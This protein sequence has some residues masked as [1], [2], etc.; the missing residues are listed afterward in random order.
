MVVGTNV[1]SWYRA[2][3]DIEDWRPD[4][5]VFPVWT[6]FL[7]PAIGTI[8]RALRRR[9]CETC[10]I[11][12]NAFDHEERGWKRRFSLYALGAGDRYVTH[13]ATLASQIKSHFKDAEVVVFPH[14]IFDDFPQAKQSLK[15]RAAIELLFFGLVR[16]Y[17][18]LDIAIEALARSERTDIQL[19]VAGEFW[20]GLSETQAQIDRL[21][22]AQQIEVIPRYISDAE[23]AE[24]F[25]RADAVL[26]PYRSVT[27]S[28]VVSMSFFY[29]RPVIVS[30]LPGISELVHEFNAGWVF[31]TG[32]VEAL[33][34]V[35]ANLDREATAQV[36]LHVN[37]CR[38]VLTWENF[39]RKIL[40][41][42][43]QDVDK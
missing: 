14:P 21:G 16:P 38:N 19:T 42:S 41:S 4:L 30:D 7:A 6:F 2:I 29:N 18:G 28:G 15:P 34:N 36:S 23:T 9:G 13:G 27:G 25:D 5:V 26:L 17:K 12:H 35:L 22:I 20:Q 37:R 24:L 31:P 40:G 39:A 32:Q 11:V 1:I 3:R 33:A 8:V 43:P 10:A